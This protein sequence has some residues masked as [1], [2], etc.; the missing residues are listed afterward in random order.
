A[1]ALRGIL[2]ENDPQL[3]LAAAYALARVSAADRK[4]AE[5][6]LRKAIQTKDKNADSGAVILLTWLHPEDAKEAVQVFTAQLQI[7]IKEGGWFDFAFLDHLSGAY[8]LAQLGPQAKP[9]TEAL[10]TGLKDS[11]PLVRLLSAYALAQA[12]PQDVKLAV[13][14]LTEIWSGKGDP[15][16]DL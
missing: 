10:R 4:D 6:V 14:A 9:A 16:G 3:S 12:N 15:K 13:A 1:P 2:K 5:A 8:G 7:K 11:E